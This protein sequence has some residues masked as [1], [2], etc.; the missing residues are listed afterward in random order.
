[1]RSSAEDPVTDYCD[2]LI[3]FVASQLLDPHRYFEQKL[4]GQLAL[5]AN[6]TARADLLR[7]LVGWLAADE[8]LTAP[9]RARLDA[10]LAR[11][12]WP[13][14][15]LVERDP[16]LALLLL[17]GVETA[18]AREQL[19]HALANSELFDSDRDLVQAN[20]QRHEH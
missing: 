14:T 3:R 12:H 11:R 10:E 6:D 2:A 18:A 1:M 17:R 5:S 13:S 8:L 15:G 7:Q 20:L 16:D 19:Q 9:Q 4:L